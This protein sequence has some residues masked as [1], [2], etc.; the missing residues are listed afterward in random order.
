MEQRQKNDLWLRYSSVFRNADDLNL[1]LQ[2]LSEFVEIYFDTDRASLALTENAG[3]SFEIFTLNKSIS[4]LSNGTLLP[5][6]G[7]MLQHVVRSKRTTTWAL[8]P[9]AGDFDLQGPG[10]R[11][12][13]F[14]AASGYQACI[15]TPLIW[16]GKVIGT[17]NVGFLAARPFDARD[18]EIME[19]AADFVSAA[20]G[21]EKY[22]EAI[23]ARDR[24]IAVL[25]H[26]IRNPLHAMMAAL[27]LLGDTE[28]D[29][30]QAELAENLGSGLM[31]L[32]NLM[33]DT[34][35]ASANQARPFGMKE[36]FFE[37]ADLI[38][39]I[40]SQAE[41][42]AAAAGLEFVM[43]LEGE[44]DPVL[45][46]DLGRLRQVVLNL[47]TN[48]IKFTAAGSVQLLVRTEVAP[49]GPGTGGGLLYVGVTD[50]GIGIDEA[51]FD[52]LFDPFYQIKNELQKDGEGSGLGLSICQ[53]F[54]KEMGS[55]LQ[56]ESKV[57]EGSTFYFRVP[58]TILART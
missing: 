21:M 10:Y 26:E 44:I 43:K 16:A 1:L 35:E 33:N 22:Q 20:L 4:G 48:A 23:Q 25:S 31:M 39:P 5:G 49:D 9:E 42:L 29:E 55:S 12:N 47:V 52:K 14:L 24:F 17:F 13:D 51:H 6:E 32:S 2:L 40:A 53:E 15:D 58:V 34:L 56:V 28:L 30:E 54:V 19:S 37:L 8:G 38:A 46:G 27:E 41:H 3:E 18:R 50:T 7:S 45:Q 36:T 11:D 57:G